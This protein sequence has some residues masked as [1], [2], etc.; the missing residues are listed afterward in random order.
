VRSNGKVNFLNRFLFQEFSD[1]ANPTIEAIQKKVGDSRLLN[2][3]TEQL[4]SSELNSLLLE[5]FRRKAD[6]TSVAEVM[7]QYNTNRFV[8]PSIVEATEF[9]RMEA[10]LFEISKQ[11]DFTPLECS[12]L[13]PLGNCSV[14]AL[15]NQNKVVSALRGTEVVADITNLLALEAAARRKTSGFDQSFVNLVSVHRH[16]RAQALPDIKGFTAHFK[17]CCAL[18]AGKDVGSLEFEKKSLLKHLQLYQTVTQ[19]LQLTG[20]SIIIKV[21]DEPGHDVLS[22]ALQL[23][24]SENLSGVALR[25]VRV[26]RA[27]H[28]YYQRLRFS[29][30][31]AH[32]GNE[33]NIGDGGFLDW[34]QKLTSNSK[35]RLLASGLG[36]ELILKM[37]LGLI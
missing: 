22:Q 6:D 19:A 15:V 30:N 1:M 34:T 23:Y 10:K 13:A 21:L 26:P 20:V 18:T 36:I 14:L 9:N 37:K 25:V 12:P 27:E 16:V 32:K 35:E 24:L 17:I 2:K 5:V 33:L 28:R 7:H 8:Q 4:T 3:L 29:V 31:I 11:H